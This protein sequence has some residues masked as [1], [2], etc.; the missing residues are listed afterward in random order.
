MFKFRTSK[1][2]F[3]ICLEIGVNCLPAGRQGGALE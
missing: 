3:K 2:D 1:F